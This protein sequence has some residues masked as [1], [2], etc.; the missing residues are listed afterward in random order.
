MSAEERAAIDARMPEI[1]IFP[2]PSVAEAGPAQTF[3]N[4]SFWGDGARYPDDAKR[5]WLDRTVYVDEDGE[6][7]VTITGLNG[8]AV[9]DS[10]VIQL[11]ASAT[12]KAFYGQ[13]QFSGFSAPM[14]GPCP[15]GAGRARGSRLFPR[16]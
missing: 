2:Q 8:A 11:R 3:F 7:P 14:G 10:Y 15:S 1:R 13:A 5:S 12:A 9:D 4:V 6:R 16:S